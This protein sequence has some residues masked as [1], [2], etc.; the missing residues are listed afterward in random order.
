MNS[1]IS[2]NRITIQYVCEIKLCREPG[3][4]VHSKLILSDK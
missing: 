3:S 4:I 1:D 2:D